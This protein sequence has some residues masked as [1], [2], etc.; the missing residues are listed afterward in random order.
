MQTQK[1]EDLE[2]QKLPGLYDNVVSQLAQMGQLET[3]LEALEEKTPEY[4]KAHKQAMELNQSLASIQQA[5]A[6]DKR[7]HGEVLKQRLLAQLLVEQLQEQWE[8]AN[9]REDDDEA[10]RID[11]Q[12]SSVV[13]QCKGFDSQKKLLL[14]RMGE[15]QE[16]MGFLQDQLSEVQKRKA[17]ASQNEFTLL[18]SLRGIKVPARAPHLVWEKTRQR[19]EDDM[20]Y[21]RAALDT[22]MDAYSAARRSSQKQEQL[23]RNSTNKANKRQGM[24]LGQQQDHSADEKKPDAAE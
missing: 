8:A 12:L 3:K 5:Q 7:L 4:A 22:A 10:D 15:N 1:P 20:K 13:N 18:S 19:L 11:V 6:R 23:S 14:E 17:A 16:R 9:D 2:A 21:N 24:Q